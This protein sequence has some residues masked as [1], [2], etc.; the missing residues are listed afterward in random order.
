MAGA[1]NQQLSERSPSVSYMW[2]RDGAL[3]YMASL[4]FVRAS[5]EYG[6]LYDIIVDGPFDDEQAEQEKEEENTGSS[7]DEVQLYLPLY[8]VWS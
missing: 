3:V 7:P 5:S 6:V 8:P 4:T 1:D 2:W